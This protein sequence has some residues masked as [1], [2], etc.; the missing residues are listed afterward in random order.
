MK[1]SSNEH[2]YDVIDTAITELWK[3]GRVVRSTNPDTRSGEY[4]YA[5]VKFRGVTPPE[6]PEIGPYL[7]YEEFQAQIN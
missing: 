1:K 6:L 7:T 5:A 2:L 3:E 4:R